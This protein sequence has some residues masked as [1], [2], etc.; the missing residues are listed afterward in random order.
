[1]TRTR[2]VRRGTINDRYGDIIRALYDPDAEAVT[3]RSLVTYQDGSQTEREI[4][5]RVAAADGGPRARPRRRLRE[6]I[7]AGA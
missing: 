7:G 5:L 4:T 3:V 1:L 2:K 6:L